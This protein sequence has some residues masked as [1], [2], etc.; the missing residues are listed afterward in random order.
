M[1]AWYESQLARVNDLAG[2][3]ASELRFDPDAIVPAAER[4]KWMAL[5]NEVEI[6]ERV[7]GMHYEIEESEGGPRGVVRLQL[8]EKIARSLVEQEL[9][10]LDRPLRFTVSRG[11]RGAVRG[12]TLGEVQ[13]A[14]ARPFSRDELDRGR[15]G[16]DE[17]TG[18]D[19]RSGRG[20]RSGQGA[21]PRRDGRDD[22]AT[23]GK[24]PHKKGKK[25]RGH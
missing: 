18:R 22:R 17:R 6:R 12:D 19:E 1:A 20:E 8:P 11:A 24:S 15:A 16:R 14:L 3:R 7:I 9:P 5:P 10:T 23:R 21:K 2:F 4:A 25:R 13:D